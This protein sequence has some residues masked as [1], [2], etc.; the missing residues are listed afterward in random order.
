MFSR[1]VVAVLLVTWADIAEAQ[2]AVESEDA[3]ANSSCDPN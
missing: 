3:P 2:D 1:L